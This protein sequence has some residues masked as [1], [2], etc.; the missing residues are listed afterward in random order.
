MLPVAGRIPIVVTRHSLRITHL[1][2][3]IVDSHPSSA[4]SSMFSLCTSLSHA[5]GPACA[6]APIGWL[7]DQPQVWRGGIKWGVLDLSEAYRRS[8]EVALPQAGQ[9]VA[10]FHAVHFANNSIDEVRGRTQNDTLSHR[11]R[12]DNPLSRARPVLISASERLSDRG[13]AKL[14]GLLAAGDPRGEVLL[15]WHTQETFRGIYDIDCPPLS[16]AYLDE[17][18]DDLTDTDCPPELGRTLS[19]WHT[20]IVNWRR[21]RVTNGPTAAIDNLD[22]R[23]KGAAFGFRST[24]TT[25]SGHCSRR[26]DRTGAPRHR[27]CPLVSEAQVIDRSSLRPRSRDSTNSPNNRSAIDTPNASGSSGRPRG[28]CRNTRR[29]P[30]P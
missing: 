2:L 25:A 15:A 17:L 9:V 4:R 6:E 1:T 5:W 3:S 26:A 21:A 20:A 16:G 24:P 13:D 30:A 7:L 18:A 29:W 8:F 12:K 28:R 19:R 14:R 11:G 10:P 22:R 23:V 27:H